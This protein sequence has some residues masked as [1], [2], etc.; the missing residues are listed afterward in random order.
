MIYNNFTSLRSRPIPDTLKIAKEYAQRLNITRVTEI[1]RL[2][3][4]GIPVYVSIRPD[5]EIECVCSG[6]GL[7]HDEAKIGAYM[8]N[9]EVALAEYKYRNTPLV[10]ATLWDVLDCQTTPERILDLCPH[11]DQEI[12]LDTEIE[13]VFAKDWISGKTFLLPAEMAYIAYK[14]SNIFGS[15]ANGLSSGNSL[16]EASIHGILEVI[17]RDILSFH[18]L[19]IEEYAHLVPPSSYPKE[20]AHIDEY[21]KAAGHEM[22]VLYIKN[23]YNIPCFIARI[24]DGQKKRLEGIS[25]GSGCHF[26]KDISLMRAVTEA[27]QRRLVYIHGGRDGVHITFHYYKGHSQKSHEHIFLNVR[28]ETKSKK[29]KIAF[30]N[31]PTFDRE[32]DSME[33]YFEEL[34]AL[35]S[36]HNY[37]FLLTVP[38]TQATESLQ[39]V[40]VV[41][42][43]MEYYFPGQKRPKAGSRLQSYAKKQ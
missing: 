12:D 1:T 10:D 8:E 16:I 25:T 4:I 13:G 6:K 39:V 34:K 26:F 21:I 40:K 2:D 36:K 3:N 42:P 27:V 20:V 33:K 30:K 32:F 11:T 7:R 43:K 37:H 5:S 35:L 18:Y 9:I 29:K 15:N 28:Q 31:I 19:N 14:K 23:E 38:F 17:E 41:I 22:V 24:F